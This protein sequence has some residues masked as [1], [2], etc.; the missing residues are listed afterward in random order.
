[1][2]SCKHEKW[3]EKYRVGFSEKPEVCKSYYQHCLK[4]G[5]TKF[6]RDDGPVQRKRERVTRER[7]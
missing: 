6:G 7:L 2:I 1:M 5:V 4:C 3:S